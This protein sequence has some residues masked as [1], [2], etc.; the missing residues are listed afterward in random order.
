MKE[1]LLYTDGSSLG[2]PGAGGYCG[3][4]VYKDKQ[5]IIKG[6]ESF[7]TS[8]RMELRAVNES[9]KA[10]KEPCSIRLYADSQYVC[11]GIN[12][13]LKGW[14][15]KRFSKVKNRD[16]WEEYIAL[17]NPHNIEAFWVRGHDGHFMNEKCD[18]IA[19]EQA[20]YFKRAGER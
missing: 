15:K 7:T 5:K 1:V 20:L 4:L 6:G 18:T 16:L 3:I 11:N 8:N 13:W 12:E 17:S 19:R 10:L 14:I 9:L 2:N